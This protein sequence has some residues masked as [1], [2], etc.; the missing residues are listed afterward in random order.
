MLKTAKHYYLMCIVSVQDNVKVL[1]TLM[2]NAAPIIKKR[3]VMRLAFGDYRAKMAA[4]EKKLKGQNTR[5]KVSTAVPSKNST[6]LKKSAFM[7]SS[8][9]SF[10]FNFDVTTA[11]DNVTV[12]EKDN[13]VVE[14]N[15]T[16]T[17]VVQDISNLNLEEKES[18]KDN[19]LEHPVNKAE[20]FQFLRSKNEFRFNFTTEG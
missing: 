18:V 13:T 14:K 2:N 11:E 3:Q 16:N 15:V 1:N 17:D 7:T 6:F 20:D 5:I 9:N 8:N 12:A 4:E 10:R 19:N